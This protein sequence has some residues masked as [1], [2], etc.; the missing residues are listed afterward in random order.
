MEVTRK[1]WFGRREVV[2]DF[3]KFGVPV[4]RVR[5]PS[6]QSQDRQVGSEPCYGVGNHD[7]DT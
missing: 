5:I 6:D 3:P 1:G 7:G 2:G 4:Q